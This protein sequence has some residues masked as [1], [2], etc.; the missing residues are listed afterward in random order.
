MKRDLQVSIY[1]GKR[2]KNE[3]VNYKGA[4]KINGDWVWEV[5][6]L[7][8]AGDAALVADTEKFGSLVKEFGRMCKKRKIKVNGSL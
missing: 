7:L 5:N 6:Q 1:R 3:C 2:E 8:F 4:L